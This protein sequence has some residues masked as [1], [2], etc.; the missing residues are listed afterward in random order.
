MTRGRV[1]TAI[2][3][4]VVAA[5]AAWPAASAAQ[6]PA[7]QTFTLAQAIRFASDNYPTVRAAL[8]EVQASSFGVSV[9]H[10]AYLPRLDSLWQS[11]RATA[12]NVFG[13]VFPQSVLPSLSGPV[14][15]SASGASAWSSAAGAL[16]SWEPFDFG[17]RKANVAGAEVAVT[18]ARAGEALTRLDVQRAVAN[19]FLAVLAGQQVV[20]SAQ[21]DLGRRDTLD[22]IAHAQADNQLRPGADASRADAERASAATRLIQA[23]TSL[24]LAETTLT[25]A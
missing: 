11:N 23:Q 18:E 10:A 17:L 24:A 4:W 12:N 1:G 9:A 5:V 19:A 25:R 14:L 22:R 7:S 20:A 6:E 16:F 3:V 13:Q 2:A 15:P 21:A 8:E